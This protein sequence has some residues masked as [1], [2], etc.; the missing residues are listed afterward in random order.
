M[1]EREKADAGLL[2]NAG[3]PALAE[4]R[5]R[6]KDLCLRFNA[7]TS[8]QQEE[9]DALT[10]QILGRMGKDCYLTAPFWCDYGY[11]IRVGDYFYTNHNCVILDCAPVTFGDEVMIGPNCCFSAAG[12]PLVAEQ[13]CAGPEFARPIT[14]GSRVWFGANVTVLPGVTIGDDTVIGAGSVVTH[15]IPS[16]VVAVGNPCR[17]LRPITEDDLIRG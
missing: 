5:D 6:V 1:T 7:L 3:D 16:G 15:D 10:G 2:Y 12:H 9:R 4:A 17:V 14:V 13:R 8:R 11:N